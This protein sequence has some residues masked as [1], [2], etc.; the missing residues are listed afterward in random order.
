MYVVWTISK[1]CSYKNERR[2]IRHCEII[3]NYM[4][5]NFKFEDHIPKLLRNSI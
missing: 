4:V 1:Y 5:G 2:F 3:S